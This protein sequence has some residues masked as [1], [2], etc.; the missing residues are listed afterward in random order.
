MTRSSA[1][2]EVETPEIRV[3]GAPAP[4]RERRLVYSHGQ[5]GNQNEYLTR[6]NKPLKR[7]R[8]S[9]FKI[10]TLIAAVSALIVFYVWNKISVNRLLTEIDQLKA[11]QL[12]MENNIKRYE[13]EIGRKSQLDRIQDIAITKLGMAHN[14]DRQIY[15][16]IDNYPPPAPPEETPR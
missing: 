16:E 8:K 2:P 15:F 12:V 10:V 1:P 7:R 5:G 6:G 4:A 9:P 11:K 14:P 13:A 3:S